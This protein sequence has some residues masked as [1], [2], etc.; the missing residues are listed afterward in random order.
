MPVVY[1]L[2]ANVMEDTYGSCSRFGLHIRLSQKRED[3]RE[4]GRQIA[5]RLPLSLLYHCIMK[6]YGNLWPALT[7]FDNLYQAYRKAI[8]GKRERP[9]VARFMF[10]AESELF[11]LQH[12]LCHKTYRPG[13]YHTFY[14]YEGKQRLISAAPFRDRVV[15]HA[16][17]NVLEPI[18]EPRFISD[19]YSNRKGK[20][21][22]QAVRRAQQFSRRFPYILKCDI[23]KYFPTIDHECLKAFLRRK[24]KCRETLWLADMIID[25]SNPQINVCDYFPE[26]H[27][28]TPFQRRKGLPI[29]NQTSQFFANVYLDP[30]DHFIKEQLH[31]KGYVRYVDDFL[32]FADT[33]ARL[34]QWNKAVITF[35]EQLRLCLKPHGTILYRVKDSF[36]FLGYRVL[37]EVILMQRKTILRFR[38]NVKTTRRKWRERR[39]TLSQVKSFI[40]GSTGHF[41]QARTEHL[42]A[43]LLKDAWF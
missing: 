11:T 37:P 2:S 27:L 16:L 35:L 13:A 19:L 26:D 30:L 38:H 41:A 10:N 5:E 40:A 34:W 39:T 1:E 28:F 6:R 20:G 21:Q 43:K 42:R 3:E 23:K 33:K 17:C 12:E 24:I 18:F 14:I 29:G 32:L 4:A 9:D 7:S 8:R 22:H 36:P 25:C 31:I 15:H